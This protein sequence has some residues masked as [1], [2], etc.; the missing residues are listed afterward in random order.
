MEPKKE[1]S[2]ILILL[3]GLISLAALV[4]FIFKGILFSFVGF[5]SF[6]VWFWVI[7]LLVFLILFLTRFFKIGFFVGL[8]SRPAL[9]F[10]FSSS[11]FLWIYF[12]LSLFLIINIFWQIIPFTATTSSKETGKISFSPVTGL[13]L[14]LEITD[15]PKEITNMLQAGQ[16]K[17]KVKNLSS[18]TALTYEDIESMKYKLSLIATDEGGPET[19][20]VGESI[21]IIKDVPEYKHGLAVNDFGRIEPGEEK[22]LTISPYDVVQIGKEYK[23]TKEQEAVWAVVGKTKSGIIW[24]ISREPKPSI[25][26]AGS[27]QRRTVW[28][29]FS[30]IAEVKEEPK[31]GFVLASVFAPP[32]GESNKVEIVCKY[33]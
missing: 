32:V 5:F 28:L 8:A 23:P 26:C 29:E 15:Y 24:I 22:E 30:K 33:R 7:F 13:K 12:F 9:S 11:W 20:Y 2:T 21:P 18:D 4:L 17:I 19:M 31:A 3:L 27:G 16:F 1:K 25:V 6:F 14:K 10:I